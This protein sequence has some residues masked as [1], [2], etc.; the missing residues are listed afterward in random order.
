MRHIDFFSG[1]ISG[2]S[3]AASHVWP[4]CEHVAFCEIDPWRR[5]QLARLWPG[6]PGGKKPE[7]ESEEGCD[8]F[9]G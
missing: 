4:D 7:V 3:F 2:F 8:A 5:K 6:V 9:N 1:A